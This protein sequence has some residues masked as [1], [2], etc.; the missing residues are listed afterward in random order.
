MSN[1]E[2][3]TYQLIVPDGHNDNTRLD[4]Y[5][6]QFIQNA[7]RN[8]V[9]D[10]IKQGYVLVNKKPSKSSYRMMPGD[11]IDITLPKPPPPEAE[12]E[13]LPLDII[14]ED[15]DLLI[16]NKK[17]GMVVHPAFGNWSG[18]LVN[19]LLY[20]I[21]ELSDLNQDEEVIRPGIVHRLDKLTSG[22]LVVAKND[23]A[24]A[25]LAEQFANHTIE[26]NYYAL[27]WGLPD[28]TGTIIADLG[29]SP[30]DRKKMSV[31]PQGEGKHAVTHFE[32]IEPFHHL[33]LLNVHL[34]TGRT[35][36]IRVHLAHIGHPVF[37]DHDYG[38]DTIRYGYSNG[39][40][41][42]KIEE[43]IKK[44]GRQCLHAKTLGF[45]HPQSG[46]F[47][48]FNSDLPDDF[49][50]VLNYFRAEIKSINT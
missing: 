27:V 24:H 3:T 47:V 40:R 18:T 50:T 32:L 9:Q 10:A 21:D 23:T 6:T 17:A 45:I 2:I 31:M 7:T 25:H 29:R 49:A 5:I 36:Q 19:G 1:K 34:E 13:N 33:A 4:I 11:I 22:L 16:I 48:R 28:K 37:G 38:G 12:P 30:K 14:Y 41:R 8:K 46:V 35:H 26:R 44:L 15:D 43:L 42:K 20:H 39:K